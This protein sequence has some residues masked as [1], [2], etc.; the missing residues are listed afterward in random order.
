MAALAP[1]RAEKSPDAAQRIATLL[2]GFSI[3]ATRPTDADIAALRGLPLGTRIY[4]SAV[5][6]KAAEE[7]AVVA[8]RLRSAGFEPVPQVAV[9]NFQSASALDELLTRLNGEAD[10]QRVLVIAGDREACG[11]F[12]G[13]IDAIDSGLFRRRGIRTLG[14]AGYPQGHPRISNDQLM[15][16]MVEKILAAETTGLNIEIVTQFCFD[17]GAI[18]DYVA[19]LRAFGVEQPIRIGL[20]GPATI[21]TLLRYAS[22][23]G[24][25]ASAHALI[26][27][28]GLI[29]GAFAQAAPD[30]IIRTL[31]HAMPEGISI[32]FFSF[33]GLGATARWAHAV[34]GGRIA[35]DRPEGFSVSAPISPAIS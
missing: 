34:A 23:C 25:R 9:R 35:L 12:R 8:A 4:I 22:R 30:E 13:A 3:E 1:L 29:R 17:A 2:R 7:I 26:R 16:A 15:R 31:A 14:I 19:T 5:P 18:L 27:R 10:V 6:G 28:T 20:T 21:G 33:G 11:P 32:H 24:V